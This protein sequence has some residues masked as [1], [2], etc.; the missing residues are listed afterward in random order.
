[1]ISPYTS[2][3]PAFC[4]RFRVKP[5]LCPHVKKYIPGKPLFVA[6]K[7]GAA[8]VLK[9]VAVVGTRVQKTYVFI[10]G[11]FVLLS[12]VTNQI[13]WMKTSVIATLTLDILCIVVQFLM[14]LK[15]LV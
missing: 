15:A 5:M 6:A 10:F 4:N 3:F 13:T 1:M 2:T 9:T 8:H 14:Q 7:H 12:H 11:K